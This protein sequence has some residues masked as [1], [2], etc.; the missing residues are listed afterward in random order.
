[1][2][3]GGGEGSRS[4]V[5]NRRNTHTHAIHQFDGERSQQH[6]TTRTQFI[7]T[8]HTQRI[9]THIPPTRDHKH[10]VHITIKHKLILKVKKS[11]TRR[12]HAQHTQRA[13]TK[14]IDAHR[15]RSR[16]RKHTHTHT[17]TIDP[18][19]EYV[20]VFNR[21]ARVFGAGLMDGTSSPSSTNRDVQSIVSRTEYYCTRVVRD[22]Y[23]LTPNEEARGG[24][25]HLH[26]GGGEV[27]DTRTKL[28][29]NYTMI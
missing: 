4:C 5:I 8:S 17:H 23:R 15:W 16:R 14:R 20:A 7:P 6:V 29:T 10:R 25:D 22:E 1:M 11:T 19:V 28:H 9:Y 24:V 13:H 2:L 26:G 18:P 21:P 3:V 12:C 27:K